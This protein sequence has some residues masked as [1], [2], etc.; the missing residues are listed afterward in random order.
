MRNLESSQ[1]SQIGTLNHLH[2]EDQNYA[3][4]LHTSIDVIHADNHIPCL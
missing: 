4:A 1:E 2:N 3:C